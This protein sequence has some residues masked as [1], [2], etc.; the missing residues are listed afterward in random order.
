LNASQQ[1]SRYDMQKS[2]QWNYDHAPEPIEIAVPA[3]DGEW[4]F[5]GLEVNSPLGMPAGPLLNGKWVL[6]YA[7]LGFDVLTYKTVRSRARDCY[8]LPNLVP[9]RTGQLS[10][11]ETRLPSVDQMSGSWAVSFGMPSAKP[12]VWR[13][14][15]ERTR[16]AL[17]EGKLLSVSVVGT[18]QDGS[19]IEELADDYAICAKWAVES[20]A[21]V[22]ETNFSCPNVSTC[23][24]QIYRDMAAAKNVASR[25]R[26]SIGT[27]PYVIKIG[28][29][30]KSEQ[31]NALLD[32]VG[33][34]INGIAMTNSVATTVLDRNGN[35]LFA[36]EL[37]GICGTAT[38]TASLNQMRQFA[39]GVAAKGLNINLIGVGGIG[40]AEDVVAQLE[41]GAKA[42]QIATAAMIHPAV[43]CEIRADFAR[44]SNQRR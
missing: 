27:T 29:M 3:F 14:D 38:R 18:V 6:Y 22:V 24:G 7:S 30:T 21:D 5:C 37:R 10:G 31:I 35:E 20:G 23:D 36:G 9:V 19:S 26:E 39:Q 13:E 4:S 33:A 42:V 15:I 12:D 2:Y 16:N 28:H 34:N 17:G 32:A 41:A 40:S 1:L 11:G 8:P 25:V 44:C 43:A